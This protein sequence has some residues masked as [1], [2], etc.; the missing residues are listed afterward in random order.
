MV[1]DFTT[2]H[3]YNAANKV[4]LNL[5]ED[6]MQSLWHIE[7]IAS[8]TEDRG[9]RKKKSFAVAIVN[10]TAEVNDNLMVK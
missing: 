6:R 7:I 5:L 4:G 1:F 2:T 3:W 8:E 10:Y 9:R